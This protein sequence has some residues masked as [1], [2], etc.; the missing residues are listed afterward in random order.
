SSQAFCTLLSTPLTASPSMVVICL[1]TTAATGTEQERIATPSTCTVQAPHCAM[2]QPYLV[3]VRPTF[4]RNAHNKGVSGST[5][6]LRDCPFIVRVGMLPTS[7]QVAA[8]AP[9]GNR[10]PPSTQTIA[11]RLYCQSSVSGA[12]STLRDCPLIVRVGICP[13]SSGSD[14]FD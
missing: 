13:Q 3:P 6:T 4:S 10:E 14:A 8:A 9:V 7:S 12:T 5:S 11:R 2:P 1:P